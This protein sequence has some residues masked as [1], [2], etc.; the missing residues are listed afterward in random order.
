MGDRNTKSRNDRYDRTDAPGAF[1]IDILNTLGRDQKAARNILYQKALAEPE[2]YLNARNNAMDLVIDKQ[3]REFYVIFKELLKYGTIGGNQ[4]LKFPDGSDYKP[5]LPEASIQKFCIGVAESIED[6][7]EKAFE[8]VY[9]VDHKN[10]AVKKMSELN[11][12]GGL[13]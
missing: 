3:V 2:K 8:E 11:K 5:M 12:T 10:L 9:P 4:V 13:P 1:D 6:I 7:C